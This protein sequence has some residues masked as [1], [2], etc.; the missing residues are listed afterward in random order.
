MDHFYLN[1]KMRAPIERQIMCEHLLALK[2]EAICALRRIKQ[3]RRSRDVSFFEDAELTREKHAALQA[4]LKHLLVGHQG[5]PCPAGT[6]PIVNPAAIPR[7]ARPPARPSPR[8][9]TAGAAALA[10][11]AAAAPAA[12]G[13]AATAIATWPLRVLRTIRS[14]GVQST[15]P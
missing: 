14:F 1:R 15:N 4:V 9:G 3:I 8:L 11:R 2:R 7:W 10:S 12:V 5:R 6:R 13:T